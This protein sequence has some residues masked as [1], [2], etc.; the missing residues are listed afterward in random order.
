[1][2]VIHRPAPGVRIVATIDGHNLTITGPTAHT[3]DEWN[4]A[5]PQGVHARPQTLDGEPLTGRESQSGRRI[6]PTPGQWA[7]RGWGDSESHPFT[8]T[9]QGG[10][11]D[12]MTPDPW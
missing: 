5:G 11:P 6:V 12:T 10:T 4:Q 9:P 8:R 7:R 3:L 2:S 1:M